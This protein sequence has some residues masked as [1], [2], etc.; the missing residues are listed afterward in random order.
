MPDLS[1][2]KLSEMVMAVARDKKFGITPE[3]VNTFEKFA[4]IHSEISEAMEAYRRKN[5]DGKD[6]LAEE[7][8]DAVIRIM[9]LAGVHKINLEKEILKKL[10]TNKN[11]E[12]KW[13]EL[14]EKHS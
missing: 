11:R 3:E 14:N 8:A 13:D 10:E 6:G 1:M 2:E 5:L 4:L 12:W 9:H 7:L